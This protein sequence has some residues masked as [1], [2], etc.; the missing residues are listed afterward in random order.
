[1]FEAAGCI[2]LSTLLFERYFVLLPQ[3]RKSQFRGKYEV[4]NG[5]KSGELLQTQNRV[6]L[7]IRLQRHGWEPV[8]KAD[9]IVTD[10]IS[11]GYHRFMKVCCK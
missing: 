4:A 1:M 6:K 2:S 10:L 5:I 3:Q 9:A 8:V 11:A 7:D